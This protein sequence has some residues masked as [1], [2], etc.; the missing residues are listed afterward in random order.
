[1]SEKTVLKQLPVLPFKQFWRKLS[2]PIIPTIRKD[3]PPYNTWKVGQVI[4]VRGPDFEFDV[5]LLFSFTC[6]VKM[7]TDEFLRIDTDSNSRTEALQ[8][9]NNFY[10]IP[11]NENTI[12]RILMLGNMNATS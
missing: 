9:I 3:K 12:V 11:I 1:M 8:K 5:T 7:L 6:M 4:R 2:Y 10:Q